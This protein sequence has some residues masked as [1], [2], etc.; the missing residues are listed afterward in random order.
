MP[1]EAT[2]NKA[3]KDE[4]W[5]GLQN[6]AALFTAHPS[7]WWGNRTEGVRAA[8]TRC[9][10]Q[11]AAEICTCRTR[12]YRCTGRA[13]AGATISIVQTFRLSFERRLH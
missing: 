13:V 1:V 11:A 9:E 3:K 5:S 12:N 8:V 4:A 2:C 10:L 6:A 7:K